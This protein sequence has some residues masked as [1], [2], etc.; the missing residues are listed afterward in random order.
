MGI[1]CST[2]Q[3]GVI[4]AGTRFIYEE[5]IKSL[6]ITVENTDEADYLLKAQ[7]LAFSP[8]Q[9]NGA[10]SDNGNIPFVATPPLFVVR[11]VFKEL[12][13]FASRWPASGYAARVGETIWQTK[14]GAAYM[15]YHN[16]VF[17]TGKTEGA[18]TTKDINSVA[19]TWV[20]AKELQQ[21]EKKGNPQD[22]QNLALAKNL[23][24]AQQLQLTGTP[25]FVVLSQAETDA[26]KVNVFPGS[27]GKDTLQLAISGSS[28]P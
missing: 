23:Q 8:T 18:L 22:N 3:A 7:I 11:F 10:Q 19:R 6:N 25:A 4:V 16:G 20:S 1:I 24:L 9:Q 28:Q 17:A 21:I 5:K 2:A 15:A 27:V 14:G 13:I 12:P 26:N